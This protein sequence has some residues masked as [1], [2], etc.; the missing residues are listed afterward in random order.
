[1]KVLLYISTKGTLEDRLHH[2]VWALA[3]AKISDR[4]LH[5]RW[6]PD[7][8]CSDEFSSL[9][10]ET[11][12][13]VLPDFETNLGV[14]I[15]Y[16]PPPGSFIETDEVTLSYVWKSRLM[17]KYKLSL[18]EFKAITKICIN[19]LVPKPGKLSEVNDV[20]VKIKELI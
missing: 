6:T 1:M 12:S 17:R 20:I 16:D 13:I 9:F 18:E 14:T 15:K 2:L 10:E 8:E 19:Y 11:D 7:E 4:K 5:L 3:Y